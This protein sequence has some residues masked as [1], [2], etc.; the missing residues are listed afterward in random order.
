MLNAPE[1]E[2]AQ[3]LN[4]VRF[5]SK[6]EIVNSGWHHVAAAK[7][8]DLRLVYA[9]R[10]QRA[11]GKLPVTPAGPG[12]VECSVDQEDPHQKGEAPASRNRPRSYT[13]LLAA[14][15]H[16]TALLP[17]AVYI[18]TIQAPMDHARRS[19]AQQYLHALA[20]EQHPTYALPYQGQGQHRNVPACAG[21]SVN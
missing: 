21:R 14:P 11:Y 8:G 6:F 17:A 16:R 10:R 1:V 4:S 13:A 19:T 15:Y 12:F 7:A 5:D 9:G 20:A 18:P 3:P 2:L